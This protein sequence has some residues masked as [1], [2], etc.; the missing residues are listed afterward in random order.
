MGKPFFLGGQAVIEGVMIRSPNY[1]SVAVRHASGEIVVR[2]EPVRSLLSRHKALDRPLIRGIFALIE[3]MILGMRS[4]NFSAEV[5]MSDVGEKDYGDLTKDRAR[6]RRRKN[7]RQ[8][9]EGEPILTSGAIALTMIAAFA[10]GL[11]LFVVVPNF[12]TDLIQPIQDRPILQNFAEGIVRLGMFIAYVVVIG[13]MKDIRRVFQYHGAEHKVVWAVEEGRPL[14]VAVA[15]GY[16]T[17]HPRCGTNFIFIVLV[18]SIIGFTFLGWDERLVLRVLSRIALLPVIAGVSYE[19]V[20][21]VAGRCN[22]WW[23][24]ILLFPG[25]SLQRLTTRRPDDSQIEVAIKAMEAVLNLEEEPEVELTAVVSPE[26][27]PAG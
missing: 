2:R 11:V 24:R 4:L 13:F 7:P 17:A 6:G 19:F 8:P 18:V 5:A 16:S 22:T 25:L 26:P 12:F 3:A 10:F 23:G 15:R 1:V 27:V 9:C 14:D 21:F 20:R